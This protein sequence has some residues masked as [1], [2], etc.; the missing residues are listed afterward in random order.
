MYSTPVTVVSGPAL[1]KVDPFYFGPI[2][3]QSLFRPGLARSN[4]KFFKNHFKKM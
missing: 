4:K 1:W 3:A 2:S